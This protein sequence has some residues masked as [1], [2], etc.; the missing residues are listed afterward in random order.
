MGEP[1]K[2]ALK[3]AVR[4]AGKFAGWFTKDAVVVTM[5]E[6]DRLM[7]DDVSLFNTAKAVIVASK[8]QQERFRANG[9]ERPVYVGNYGID[10][11]YTPDLKTFPKRNVF[12]TAGRTAH[13]LV[14]KGLDRVI[15]AFLLAFPYESDVVL[16][17]KAQEDCPIMPV[18]STKIQVIREWLPKDEMIRW[19]RQGLA[20]VNGSAGECWGFHVH[21]AMAC[22]RAVIGADFGG[23]TEYFNKQ[24]GY[25]V[26]HKLVDANIFVHTH[27]NTFEPA[28]GRWAEMS[29]DDLAA[30][31]RTVYERP[32]DAFLKGTLAA[33]D[34]KHL[35]LERMYSTYAKLILKYA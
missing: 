17:V 34:V 24:N 7:R 28:T 27:E 31:M 12:L 32:V 26:P 6:T 9:V 14:R 33:E 16:Q 10:A 13:G 35:T 15:C 20:Y 2:G 19:Y 3:V 8:W 25:V 1:R 18:H 30:A 4:P 21:E 29:V 23:V 11:D 5:W 22:G